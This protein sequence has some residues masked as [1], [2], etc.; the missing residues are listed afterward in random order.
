M[1]LRAIWSKQF[2]GNK[3]NMSVA[4]NVKSQNDQ[5]FPCWYIVKYFM[6]KKKNIFMSGS[7]KRGKEINKD[8]EKYFEQSACIQFDV[9][10]WKIVGFI[11]QG[12]I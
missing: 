3:V 6:K 4:N 5:N 11:L 10:L 12:Q 1:I 9:K 8:R 7:I 2:S